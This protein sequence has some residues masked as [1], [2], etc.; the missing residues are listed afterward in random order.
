MSHAIKENWSIERMQRISS[1]NLDGY[2]GGC[3]GPTVWITRQWTV[4]EN[5]L[6]QRVVFAIFGSF[7]WCKDYFDVDYS[8]LA[9]DLYEGEALINRSCDW[10]L[11]SL[12]SEVIRTT[13]DVFKTRIELPVIPEGRKNETTLEEELFVCFSM[14]EWNEYAG[15]ITKL[16]EAKANAREFSSEGLD[17]FIRACPNVTE[18]AFNTLIKT[19][20]EVLEKYRGRLTHVECYNDRFYKEN[21]ARLDALGEGVVVTKA[22]G[23][24]ESVHPVP[25]EAGHNAY[26]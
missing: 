10:R 8:Q 5:T 19:R 13:A 12:F 25:Q 7:Q 21:R 18:I 26:A 9:K 20:L 17:L 22:R 2:R 23:F 1:L 11:H 3:L 6:W 16:D 14:K 24:L 15:S 4:I